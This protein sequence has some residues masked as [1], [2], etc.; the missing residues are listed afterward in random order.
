TAGS[1]SRAGQH[2]RSRRAWP[3]PDHNGLEGP[4]V[5]E[6]RMKSRVKQPLAERRPDSGLLAGGVPPLVDPI[7]AQIVCPGHAILP[8]R[9]LYSAEWGESDAER[10]ALQV[11]MLARRTGDEYV[12]LAK[13]HADT[14][15]AEARTAAEQTVRE[16]QEAA[17]R[18]RRDADRILSEAKAHA[19]E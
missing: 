12:A 9:R 13:R 18:V 17:D 10:Q 16:A 6:R 19:A 2:V 1:G 7:P 5:A 11:L 15:R 14:T 4:L 8:G 3:V